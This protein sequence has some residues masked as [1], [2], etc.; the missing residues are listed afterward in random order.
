MQTLN[1]LGSLLA[2]FLPPM[3]GFLSTKDWFLLLNW[4]FPFWRKSERILKIWSLIGSFTT[5]TMRFQTGYQAI[6]RS[7]LSSTTLQ[8]IKIHSLG[9]FWNTKGVWNGL[10]GCLNGKF[11]AFPPTKPYLT[12]TKQS[13]GI[14]SRAKGIG[15][16][17]GVIG[18]LIGKFDAFPPTKP[19][20]NAYETLYWV[21]NTRI[22]WID[23]F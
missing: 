20:F 9:L 14:F 3:F 22:S 23:C 6:K 13:V 2:P 8:T 5:Q 1:G 16:G 15:I 12:H 17:I 19:Y 4:W 10:N 11:V 21:W 7:Y 18:S